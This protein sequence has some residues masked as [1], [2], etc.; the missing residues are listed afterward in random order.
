LSPVSPHKQG[1]S[2]IIMK[3]T[4]LTGKVD[5]IEA[6]E[7]ANI[8][9]KKGSHFAGKVNYGGGFSEL[10]EEINKSNTPKGSKSKQISENDKKPS[11]PLKKTIKK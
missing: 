5:T 4:I 2:P 1:N 8:S 3:K 7:A 6:V 11:S 10:T 9:P